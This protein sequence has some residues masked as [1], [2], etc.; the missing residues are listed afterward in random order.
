MRSKRAAAPKKK[1]VRSFILTLGLI[2][3]VGS[4]VISIIGDQLSLRERR[5]EL[6]QKKAELTQQRAENERLQSVV[7]DEDKS[8]YIEKIAREKLGYGMPGEKVFYDI[9]PGA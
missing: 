3:L 1:R 6:E 4:F 9:T 7:D 2:L 5:T 8:D